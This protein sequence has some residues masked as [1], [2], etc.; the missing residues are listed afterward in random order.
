MA[1][2]LFPVDLPELEWVEFESDGFS[3]PVSGVIFRADKPTCCGV[4]LGGTN[5][6]NDGLTFRTITVKT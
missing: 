4:P 3:R 5:G 2:R 1:K 6:T